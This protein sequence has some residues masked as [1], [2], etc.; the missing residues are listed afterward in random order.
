VIHLFN[1][2]LLYQKRSKRQSLFNHISFFYEAIG[3][4][5][6][7]RLAFLKKPFKRV[8]IIGAR[9]FGFK[10][11]FEKI[12]QQ[13]PELWVESCFEEPFFNEKE[14]LFVVLNE[15]H[16]PFS[17]ESFD[18]IIHF[19]SMQTLNAIPSFLKQSHSILNPDGL[20]VSVFPGG[21]TLKEFKECMMRAEIHHHQGTSP[22]CFP[23]ILPESMGGLLQEAEFKL[24]VV[25]VDR[26]TMEYASFQN[27][28]KDIKASSD[29]QC[30]VNRS[31]FLLTPRFLKT[32]EEFYKTLFAQ[33]GQLLVTVDMIYGF[34]WRYHEDQQKPLRRGCFEVSLKEVL[35]Q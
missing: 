4:D 29:P 8:L 11:L 15:E 35:E 23:N 18:L 5:L 31:S 17:P 9:Q 10:T 12:V 6:C 21:D 22:R 7:E 13:T 27:F 19:L 2:S 34:G 32:V 14:G 28:M 24:P 30:L 3:Q 33:D 16:L 25:D 20:F 26:F 1:R